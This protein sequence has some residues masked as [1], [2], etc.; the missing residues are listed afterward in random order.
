MIA[1]RKRT[2]AV[3]RG[4]EAYVVLCLGSYFFGASVVRAMAPAFKLEIESFV[5]EYKVT[6]FRVERAIV[7]LRIENEGGQQP[8]VQVRFH[9]FGFTYPI[10]VLSLLAAWPFPSL[11]RRLLALGIGALLA[12]AVMMIDLPAEVLLSLAERTQKKPFF[13]SFFFENGG[14]QF[15]ALM[16]FLS[17][18]ALDARQGREIRRGAKPVRTVRRRPLV[19]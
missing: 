10:L 6:E 3:L 18:I 13:V 5:P 9:H 14:R 17:S 7:D 2:S 4:V 19:R 12:T 16:I 15:L 1:G 8:E 11:R